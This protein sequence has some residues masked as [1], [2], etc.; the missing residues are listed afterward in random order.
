S[1]LV[2]FFDGYDLNVIPFTAPDVMKA[3]GLDTSMWKNVL[4]IGVFGTLLGS[5]VFGI[6]GDRRGRRIA[7]VSAT[8]AFGFLTLLFA[9]AAN[10]HQQLILRL[11]NGIALGGAVPLTW[12]LSVE[13][14]PRRYRATIVTVIM[15]GYGIGV[16]VSGPIAVK[17]LI[18]SFGWQ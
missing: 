3:Y 1:S 10:Y 11:L 16:A 15:M 7:I 2:M 4:T 14:V 8:A 17:L 18:P 9:A 12:A 6:L 5:V 13:Y